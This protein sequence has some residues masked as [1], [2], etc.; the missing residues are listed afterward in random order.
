MT[1]DDGA[2]AP[3]LATVRMDE[4]PAGTPL[5]VAVRSDMDRGFDRDQHRHAEHLIAWSAT[6]TIALRT[7]GRDWLVPPT[8]ALWIPAGTPHA[9]QVLRPGL[10]HAV[11][12][13]ADGCPITWSEPTGVTITPLVRELIVH[14]GRH[15]ERTRTRT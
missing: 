10:A 9:L 5:L 11:L 8:H 4:G 13:G 12:L 3:L 2:S 14:L 6:A 1:D 7:G 15:T